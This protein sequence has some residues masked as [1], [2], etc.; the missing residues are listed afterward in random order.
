M[1]E[2]S[3]SWR[4]CNRV[5]STIGAAL[6]TAVVAG[7]AKQAEAYVTNTA[8][9]WT[10][11]PYDIKVWTDEFQTEFSLESIRS[12]VLVRSA[13]GAWQ[14]LGILLPHTDVHQG[15]YSGSYDLDVGADTCCDFD[16]STG[17]L[18]RARYWGWAGSDDCSITIYRNTNDDNYSDDRSAI[19]DIQGIATHEFGHCLGLDHPTQTDE[20]VMKQGQYYWWKFPNRFT[21]ADDR[22]GVRAE[23]GSATWSIG[24]RN[25]TNG[26]YN[27]SIPGA[28]TG[29]L[30]VASATIG[31]YQWDLLGYLNT[32]SNSN[33]V[34]R[35]IQNMSLGP[36]CTVTSEYSYDGVAIAKDISGFAAAFRANDDSGQVR[37]MRGWQ[38]SMST[39]GSAPVEV[40]SGSKTRRRP[41][42]TYDPGSGRLVL[43]YIDS[44]T[45]QFHSRTT[46]TAAGGWT[47]NNFIPGEYSDT[48]VGIACDYWSPSSAYKCFLTFPSSDGKHTARICQS[49]ISSGV[50]TLESCWNEDVA[51]YANV[52]PA[53]RIEN[54]NTLRILYSGADNGRN[55]YYLKRTCTS[56]SCTVTNTSA[57]GT[58]ILA[59]AISQRIEAVPLN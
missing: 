36:T 11:T 7:Y 25:V 26:S 4:Q 9:E 1:T 18:G 39:C 32:N 51:W 17:C 28:T 43:V 46:N 22:A 56:T 31:G 16:C 53:I 40:I 38:P 59:P 12:E 49:R 57:G 30:G 33:I 42:V 13:L 19:Y 54:Y 45:G 37:I 5:A 20:A 2:R 48:P 44:D 8:I 55:M 27:L 15:N 23:Q 52:A 24:L 34:L 47:T 41:S 21:R 10:S 35:S 14:N 3:A 6:L 29:S 50:L 58:S